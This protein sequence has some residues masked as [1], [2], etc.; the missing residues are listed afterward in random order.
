M[1]P[2]ES[3][4]PTSTRNGSGLTGSNLAQYPSRFP[5]HHLCLSKGTLNRAAYAHHFP[6]Y[7]VRPADQFV[8]AV[9]WT[10]APNAALSHDTD[11]D[12]CE[13]SDVNP[14]TSQVTVGKQQRLRRKTD[15]TT[16][17]Y[18]PTSRLMGGGPMVTPQ[19]LFKVVVA[20]WCRV[21]TPWVRY[22]PGGHG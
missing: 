8:L 16:R 15:T 6:K 7:P 22:K 2:R 21:D 19:G 10:R 12:A 18:L 1:E 14:N 4:S 20:A 13:T 11:L 5:D 9:L 3:T 17:T